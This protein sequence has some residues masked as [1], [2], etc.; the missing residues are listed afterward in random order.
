M[1]VR[2]RELIAHADVAPI[3]ASVVSCT[4]KNTD[5]KLGTMPTQWAWVRLA[6]YSVLPLCPGGTICLVAGMYRT[7]R[8]MTRSPPPAAAAAVVTGTPAA[9]HLC[10]LGLLSQTSDLGHD[11]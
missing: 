7:G 9:N 1:P 5:L 3:W 4:G 11:S 2:P 6:L 10:L 8:T